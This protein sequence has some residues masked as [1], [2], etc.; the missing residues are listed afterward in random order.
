MQLRLEPMCRDRKLE[1]SGSRDTG[2]RGRGSSVGSAAP[3]TQSMEVPSVGD[4]PQP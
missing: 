4:G 2:P 1:R 3:H